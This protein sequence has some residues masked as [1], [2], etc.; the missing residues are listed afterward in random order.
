[1]EL[2]YQKRL[3]QQ[4]ERRG[5]TLTATQ[6]E[7]LLQYLE[8]LLRWR[9]H[10]NLTGL[11]DAE[12]IIDV[13]IGESLDFFQGDLLVPGIRLL[14]LGT[15]AGVP[16][17]PLAICSRSLHFTLLD[18]S[19]KKIAFV[20]RVVSHVRLD[21]CQPCCNT[22]EDF[23]RSLTPTQRFDAVVSRGVGHITHLLRLAA[24]LLRP[25]GTLLV[26]K[27][28]H[29]P[30]LQEATPLLSS[31]TWGEVQTLPLPPAESVPWVLMAIPRLA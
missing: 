20:R 19:A 14:D 8:L 21:N 17:I 1:M 29:T 18:R 25:G 30:E 9:P 28:L 27:P 3:C 16:G 7:R 5:I 12:R 6:L 15:G 4:C 22:A 13:L 10:L 23:A 2:N 31:A 26:R 24:P 11:R